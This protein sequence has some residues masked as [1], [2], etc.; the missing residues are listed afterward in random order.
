MFISG[1][2]LMLVRLSIT[3]QRR[4]YAGD[5]NRSS[6]KFRGKIFQN[7]WIVSSFNL[8]SHIIPYSVYN[9]DL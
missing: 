8:I 9:W 3:G 6:K 7:G 2:G 4:L 1:F 5:S